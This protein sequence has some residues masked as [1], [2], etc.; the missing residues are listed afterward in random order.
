MTHFTAH[1]EKLRKYPG[2]DLAF[3]DIFAGLFVRESGVGCVAPLHL[4][5]CVSFCH[6]NHIFRKSS[7]IATIYIYLRDAHK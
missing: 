1:A 3:L 2:I 5:N 4:A 7:Y 6:I